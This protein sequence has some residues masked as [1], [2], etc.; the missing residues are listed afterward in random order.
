[1]F[2]VTDLYGDFGFFIIDK[3]IRLSLRF[4]VWKPKQSKF[5]WWANFRTDDDHQENVYGKLGS[6]VLSR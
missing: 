4:V 5:L 6:A 1:M 2:C 3:E